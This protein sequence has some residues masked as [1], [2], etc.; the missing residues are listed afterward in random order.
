MKNL[1]LFLSY[2]L[3]KRTAIIVVILLGI[4]LWLHLGFLSQPQE[5]VFD[6]LHFG[7]F[8]S[9]YFT[10]VYYFDIH[11]PLGKLLLALGAFFGGYSQYVQDYGAFDFKNIG[12]PYGSMPY[13]WF[14][15]LPALAGSFI[16]LAVFLFMRSL[17]LNDRVSL[18]VMFGLVFENA[19]LAH[20]R[21]MLLDSFLISFGFLGLAAFL[22][23]R[24]QNY[25]WPWL[26][27]SCLL[28]G[29]VISVKWT[30]L[31]FWGLAGLI[32]VYDFFRRHPEWFSRL[33]FALKTFFALVLIPFMVYFVVFSIHLSL[34]TRCPKLNEGNGCDFMSQDFRQNRLSLAQKFW[35]LN[36][37]MGFYNTHLKTPHNYGSPA[38]SWPV[39][40]RPI[41][42]WHEQVS[43]GIH[44]RIYLLG[45]PVLWWLASASLI[46]FLVFFGRLKINGLTKTLLLVGYLA[47]FLPFFSVSRVLFLYHY[48]T[49]LIFSVIILGIVLESALE[50][51]SKRNWIVWLVLSI[52]ILSCFIFFLPLT[53][54]LPLTD[55]WYKLHTWLPSWI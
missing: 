10:G 33:E 38:W 52:L 20:T 24:A 28:F 39:M 54:G 18:F 13:V 3:Q 4:S 6:E 44:S 23:A 9:A 26:V 16:P 51:S 45:N 25:S 42:Y 40:S 36:Q 1:K 22:K 17:K 35:E 7:K 53:M 14:R 55:A 5:T 48:F 32:A 21:L 49:A 47:N 50:P 11:P 2:L 12:Q 43:P 37:K 30:G 34:L 46:C 31:S 19:L 41:F 29:L 8:S 27:V 15:L